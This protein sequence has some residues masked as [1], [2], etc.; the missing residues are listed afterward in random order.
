MSGLPVDST[1]IIKVSNVSQGFVSGD[2]QISVLK[3][4]NFTIKANSFNIVFGPSGS[5]KSTLLNV[6]AGLQAPTE[7]SV[8]IGGVDPYSLN[9]DELARFRASRVGFMHQTNHW[10]KSLNVLE[11]VSL[12]LYFLGYSKDK[13]T[14]LAEVALDRVN[15]GSYAKKTPMF[16]SGGEQQRIGAARALANDPLFIIADEPTGNL[17]SVHGDMIMNL[18]LNAQSEFR[19]TIIVVT[20]NMEY[21]S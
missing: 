12:P 3:K 11:N 13:A 8:E 17:D 14:K 4:V 1:D 2:E 18:L 20:H 7:G 6:I 10:V 9:K 19:R 15:M 16:L 5:G 21:I